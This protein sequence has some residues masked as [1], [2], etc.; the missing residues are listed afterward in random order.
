M[1]V[2]L[3]NQVAYVGHVVSHVLGEL[4]AKNQEFGLAKVPLLVFGPCDDFA[5]ASA[6]SI[7]WA[8]TRE[9]FGE[10]QRQGAP[11]QPGSLRTRSVAV[12][13]VLFGGVEPDG[14]YTD[15]QAPY[16]DC[17]LT[18]ALLS[19]LTNALQRN[20]SQHA[21]EV[22][23][24][25]WFNLGRTGIGMSCELSVLIKL[26]IVRE[27]NPTVRPTTARASVEISKP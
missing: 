9:Q 18:E 11:G 6:P 21:Y 1:S 25:T 7:Y 15:D 5:N 14:T 26:P 2:D 20:L 8:P 3:T 19:K 12:S 4:K 16:H 13:F 27:D 17:D 22:E 23:S 24:V 10:P